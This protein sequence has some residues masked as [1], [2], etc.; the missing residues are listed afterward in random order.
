VSAQRVHGGAGAGAGSSSFICLLDICYARYVIKIHACFSGALL[1]TAFCPSA[2]RHA[3]LLFYTTSRPILPSACTARLR[4][5]LRPFS[6]PPIFSFAATGFT[7]PRSQLF[8]HSPLAFHADAM[9]FNIDIRFLLLL[10]YHMPQ[11]MPP[12]PDSLLATP[13]MLAF[14][15]GTSTS[16]D[17]VCHVARHA[18]IEAVYCCRRL[19][20]VMP[21][22]CPPH[23]T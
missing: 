10:R 5:F 12:T 19:L 23:I 8:L 20:R 16:F 11:H 15:E 18:A 2:R 17:S 21:S 6:R 7:S 3:L 9:P 13:R 14:T 1:N 4:H 22:I